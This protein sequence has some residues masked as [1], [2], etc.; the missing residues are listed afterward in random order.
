M[1][2]VLKKS[3]DIESIL[4]AFYCFFYGVILYSNKYSDIMFMIWRILFF[5]VIMI[6]LFLLNLALSR[7][8]IFILRSFVISLFYLRFILILI[9][10]FF[11]IFSVWRI[12]WSHSH[13]GFLRYILVFHYSASLVDSNLLL[14]LFL[15]YVFIY[16]NFFVLLYI[17]FNVFF[18]I[19]CPLAFTKF[20]MIINKFSELIILIT[21]PLINFYDYQILIGL[22]LW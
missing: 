15:I 20:F 8:A 7:M 9:C 14:R 18:F 17:H 19:V 3:L 4:L 12:D 1:E 5:M 2:Y 21:L 11:V 22:F 13:D 10:G 16:I 6:K